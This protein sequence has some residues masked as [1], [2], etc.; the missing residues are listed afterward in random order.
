MATSP[1]HC[2]WITAT[3]PQQSLVEDEMS[4]WGRQEAQTLIVWTA[5][6]A[7]APSSDQKLQTV[8]TSSKKRPAHWN[9]HPRKNVAYKYNNAGHTTGLKNWQTPTPTDCCPWT[10]TD[11]NWIVFLLFLLYFCLQTWCDLNWIVSCFFLLWFS[12]APWSIH[13]C[14]CTSTDSPA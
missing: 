3:C 4:C 5:Q 9:N 1:L 13:P 2:H 14:H 12:A 7:L 11:L 8:F 6:R 10:L